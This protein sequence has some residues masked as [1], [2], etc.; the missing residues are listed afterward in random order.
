MQIVHFCIKIKKEFLQHA[1]A[2]P[3][4]FSFV[5]YVTRTTEE[6]RLVIVNYSPPRQPFYE[7][8]V[9]NRKTAKHDV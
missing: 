5:L 3:L 9:S 6:E 1:R 2:H 4:Q 7:V 8:N